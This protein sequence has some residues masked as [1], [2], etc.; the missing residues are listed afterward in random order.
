[1]AD[2]GRRQ[3]K[4]SREWNREEG[5]NHLEEQAESG[6]TVRAYCLAKGL[7]EWTF[8]N[9]RRRLEVEARCVAEP[10]VVGEGSA[11]PAF[12]ELVVPSSG[13]RLAPWMTE[14]VL[15][16]ERCLRV[17][18]GFDEETLRRLVTVLESLPC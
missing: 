6:L 18:P 5:R 13:S 16:G 14:V 4:R 10:D 3:C 1:M 8:Y 12:T 7:K 9:W 11:R 17:G 2:V 15:R